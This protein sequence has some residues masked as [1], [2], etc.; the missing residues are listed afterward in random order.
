M[1][2]CD[3]DDVLAMCIEAGVLCKMGKSDMSSAFRN[4]GIR[5]L[6][7]KYLIMKATNTGDHLS[8]Y[9]VDKCLPFRVVISCIHFQCFSD[10]VGH[11]VRYKTGKKLINY[12]DDYFF[13]ALLAHLCNGQKQIFIKICQMIN[14]PVALEK[15]FWA[16]TQL[17]FLGIL[18]DSENQV[19]LIPKEKI[20]KGVKLI[21]DIL[22]R[23]VRR[24][25]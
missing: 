5:V 21:L 17:V 12:L 16:T 9:F 7:F 18:M 10:A 15:T 11:I 1:K 24:L 14:F 8:Y 20:E 25:Q 13:A 19:V 4:L 3:F 6:H 23:K 2:Y 22:E